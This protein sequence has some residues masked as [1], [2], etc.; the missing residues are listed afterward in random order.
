MRPDS[1]NKNLTAFTTRREDSCQIST[2]LETGDILLKLA[3]RFMVFNSDGDF[4]NQVTFKDNTD[5]EKTIYRTSLL[6]SS[7]MGNI[8][9]RQKNNYHPI[10]EYDSNA[11][12]IVGL[13]VIEEESSYFELMS[14]FSMEE[15]QDDLINKYNRMRLIAMSLHNKYFIFEDRIDQILRVYLLTNIQE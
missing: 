1:N 15:M 6:K 2:F 3:N 5:P 14:M 11:K 13:E 8:N 7:L 12:E 9:D 4:I 10:D